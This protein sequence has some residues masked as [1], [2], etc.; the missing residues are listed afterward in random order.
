M[1]VSAIINRL[2]DSEHTGQ[3]VVM[4]S[5]LKGKVIK[6][7]V[8]EAGSNQRSEFLVTKRGIK[9]LKKL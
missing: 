7:D 9:E 2:K 1:N 5:L 8:Y 3:V 6:T 4:Y